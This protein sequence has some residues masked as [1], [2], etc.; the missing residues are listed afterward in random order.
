MDDINAA[1]AVAFEKDKTNQAGYHWE[2]FP[3]SWVCD[4]VDG[5]ERRLPMGRQ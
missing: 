3:P 5:T 2:W 1:C 4:Y